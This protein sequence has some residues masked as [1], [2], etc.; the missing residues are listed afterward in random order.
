VPAWNTFIAGHKRALKRA[1]Q[2]EQVDLGNMEIIL[3]MAAE[4]RAVP[5][6]FK[7]NYISTLHAAQVNTLRRQAETL[8]LLKSYRD[9]A[10]SKKFLYNRSRELRLLEEAGAVVRNV[11]EFSTGDIAHWYITLFEKRWQKKPKAYK[12]MHLQLEAL[13]DF[14]LGKILFLHNKPIAIQLVFFTQS[15]QWVSCEFLNAGVDPDFNH[16]SAGSVLTFLN[17]QWADNFAQA[18]GKQLRYSF[19]RTDA[20]YKALWCNSVPLYKI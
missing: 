2:Y 13:K 11:N 17:T 19:G 3:P 5:L 4:A 20:D 12:A 1:R 6:R 15:P 7:G 8:S 9:N 10:F 14:L 16:Y 18:Q